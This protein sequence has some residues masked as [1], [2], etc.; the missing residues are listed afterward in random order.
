MCNICFLV[1]ITSF[2]IGLGRT[3]WIT[4]VELL[5][6][7]SKNSTLSWVKTDLSEEYWTWYSSRWKWCRWRCRWGLAACGDQGLFVTSTFLRATLASGT[8]NTCLQIW[9]LTWKC[10]LVGFKQPTQ[11]QQHINT[12]TQDQNRTQPTNSKPQICGLIT[13]GSTWRFPTTTSEF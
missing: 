10:T 9:R 6:F 8:T 5:D 13:W 12:T 3:S 2:W 11:P 4:Y 7:W 1:L